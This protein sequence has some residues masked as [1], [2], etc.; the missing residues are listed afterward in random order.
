MKH[1][2]KFENQSNIAL[3]TMNPTSEVTQEAEALSQE[4]EATLGELVEKYNIF[5]DKYL[6]DFSKEG[7]KGEQIVLDAWINT[8]SKSPM[9]GG[10]IYWH[11]DN[12]GDWRSKK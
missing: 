3:H 7:I 5:N 10:K 1:L 11:W 2:K 4:I 12:E 6:K 9:N 8:L